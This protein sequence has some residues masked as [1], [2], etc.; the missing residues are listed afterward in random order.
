[1]AQH[2]T[3]DLSLSLPNLPLPAFD[4]LHTRTIRRLYGPRGTEVIE[5]LKKARTLH[6]YC[7]L[8][9]VLLLQLTTTATNTTAKSSKLLELVLLQYY[10]YYF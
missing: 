1:M 2:L 3:E 6:N 9:M 7:L 4:A 8:V 10:Y 5:L